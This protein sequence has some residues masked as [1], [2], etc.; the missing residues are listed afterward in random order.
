MKHIGGRTLTSDTLRFELTAAAIA[1]KLTLE[2][3]T[4]YF[5]KKKHTEMIWHLRRYPIQ[6]LELV[7]LIVKADNQN[8]EGFPLR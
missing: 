2:D 5:Q 8:T 1:G 7:Q 3:L 4:E 6:T